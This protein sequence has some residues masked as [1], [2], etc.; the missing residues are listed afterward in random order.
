MNTETFQNLATGF[1]VRIESCEIF[2]PNVGEWARQ[3]IRTRIRSYLVKVLRSE[4][5][6]AIEVKGF[7]TQVSFSANDIDRVCLLNK[8][9][10]KTREGLTIPIFVDALNPQT[11]KW[12]ERAENALL[13][14]E[15]ELASG[16]SLQ[17]YRNALVLIGRHERANSDTVMLLCQTADH[18]KNLD[19]QNHVD[20]LSFSVE[21]L[22]IDLQSLEPLVK[23]FAISDDDMRQEMLHQA[24][25]AEL[26]RLKVQVEPL[27]ARINQFLDSF[28]TN[29][30]SK[31]AI[32]ISRLAEAVAELGGGN[33]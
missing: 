7:E 11:T 23:R 15:L 1:N 9:L 31:E 5:R 20:G 29:P 17:V 6:V 4:S 12:L 14:S 25:D 28:G 24:S 2:N 30:L 27:L 21:R 32:L 3:L 26:E 33:T 8:P 13:L 19:A 10:I 18:L 16:E 22:P